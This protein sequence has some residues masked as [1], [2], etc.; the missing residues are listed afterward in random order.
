LSPYPL[1]EQGRC[2]LCRNGLLGFDA[3]YSFGSYEG[4]LRKLI[5]LLKYGGMRP[6]ARPLGAMLA[7]ALP[8]DERID[9]IVPMP[10]HW[11]RRW[12]RGF[13]QAELLAREI[14]RRTGLP[15]TTPVRRRVATRAQ[16]GLTNAQRR[17]NV[18]GAFA[19]RKSRVA[20][21]RVLL[22]DD[23]MTTGATAASCARALKAAGADRVILL[24]LARVDRRIVARP[25]EARLSRD[26][27]M[28]GAE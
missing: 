19:A 14:G 22:V 9:E 23:V 28:Q 24:T 18:V 12:Q 7:R 20:G 26:F 4:A 21:K 17:A 6:L 5:H 10:L 1:D 27:L 2:R 3:A 16:A 15:V 11:R 13:N 25:E 8:L